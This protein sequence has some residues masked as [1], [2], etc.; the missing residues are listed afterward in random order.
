MSDYSNYGA[1]DDYS[2]EDNYAGAYGGY[3]D[4]YDDVMEE[5][6][7]DAWDI[8][9]EEFGFDEETF[10]FE[11]D[12]LVEY[13]DLKDHSDV[14]TITYQSLVKL[15]EMTCQLLRAWMKRSSASL[16][17]DQDNKITQ[18]EP[19]NY[20]VLNLYQL[21]T[22]ERDELKTYSVAKLLRSFGS[23]EEVSKFE[24]AVNQMGKFL[25]KC[26]L[27]ILG[28]CLPH[29]LPYP[30]LSTILSHLMAAK[31]LH[32]VGLV[33]KLESSKMMEMDYMD[34]LYLSL[35]D[36]YDHIKVVMF[37]IEPNTHSTEPT[38]NEK[39][40]SLLER[41]K[42]LAESVNKFD[43]EFGLDSLE[44]ISDIEVGG[45]D[46][47]E[48]LEEAGEDETQYVRHSEDG[49]AY[50]ELDEKIEEDDPNKENYIGKKSLI[51]GGQEDK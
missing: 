18:D 14:V 20:Y 43:T 4:L 27:D 15:T 22:K 21:E 8:G 39:K 19:F 42:L 40:E 24:K 51:K 32:K 9:Y 16:G 26:L 46:M 28:S 12:P 10:L 30:V 36:V 38:L 25:R 31:G 34:K 3:D 41:F 2:D 50:P 1:S 35:A 11:F 37:N 44:I 7:Y 33:T 5:A 17:D 6:G 48:E 23:E 49:Q 29:S 45:V 13:F 47:F